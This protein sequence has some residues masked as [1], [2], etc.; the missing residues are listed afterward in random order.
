MASDYFAH[1]TAVID[2]GAVIG[3]N[4]KIWHFSHISPDARLGPD[5]NLGHNVFVDKGVTI[6]QHVKIQNNVSLVRG[7][8]CEDEVFFGPSAVFTNIKNPR[9][10]VNRHGELEGTLIKHG[11]TIG[12][13]TTIICGITI[14]TYAFIGAGAVITKNI[15]AYALYLGNPGRHVGWMSACGYRLSLDENY[16]ARCPGTGQLYKKTDEGL[17]PIAS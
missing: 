12:A 14:G 2:E 9:S 11:A 13:N 1:E 15:P 3:A 4:T 5:C 10:E 7:V 17:K 6:G 16:E 8:K